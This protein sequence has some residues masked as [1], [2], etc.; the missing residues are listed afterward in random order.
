LV[1]GKAAE[2][3]LGSHAA[4]YA[5]QVCPL[6]RGAWGS[7]DCEGDLKE[8]IPP[9]LIPAYSYLVGAVEGVVVCIM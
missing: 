6:L 5:A 3:G 1:R 9:N 4:V 8:Y 7:V 2:T